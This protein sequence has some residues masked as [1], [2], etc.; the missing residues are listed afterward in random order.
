MVFHTQSSPEPTSPLF[1]SC[2][3]PQQASL[4]KAREGGDREHFQLP[5]FT[6]L[7]AES[8]TVQHIHEATRASP[9]GLLRPAEWGNLCVEDRV[10]W[11]VWV[12]PTGA[13]QQRTGTRGMSP[14]LSAF[15]GLCTGLSTGHSRFLSPLWTGPGSS[16]VAGF[17]ISQYFT[18]KIILEGTVDL[19]VRSTESIFNLNPS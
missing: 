14:A 2:K 7:V 6:Q 13:D 12:S 17:I 3:E 15:R 10:L 19:R 16:W 8:R 18:L 11:T 1:R 9:C 5:P 4:C